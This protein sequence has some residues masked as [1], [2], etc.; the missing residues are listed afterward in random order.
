MPDEI[1]EALTRIADEYPPDLV[2]E[3]LADRPRIAANIR[4]VTEQLGRNISIC[5][6]GGG[7]GLFS[8]GCA[9]L[10]M[11]AILVDDFRD[12]VIR[13]HT[14]DSM[15]LHA[16]YGVEVRERDLAGEGLGLPA[17]S[18]DAVTSFETLEHLHHSARQF[19]HSALTALRAGGLLVISVPNCMDLLHRARTLCG[20]DRWSALSDWYDGAP[21]RGHVREASVRDLRYIAADLS[22]RAPRIFGRNWSLC[23]ARS[24]VVRGAAK[25]IDPLLRM[26]PHLCSTLYLVGRRS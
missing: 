18:V 21:F 1:D 15:G 2:A 6:A 19:L 25:A 14:V 12:S 17:E 8:L 11:R 10:G 3:Q 24:R 5:D 16:R 7:I 4:L 26:R 23:A 13:R 22:L 20:C 9:A